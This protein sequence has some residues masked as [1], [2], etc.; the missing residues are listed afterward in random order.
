MVISIRIYRYAFLTF[1]P[2]QKLYYDSS[3][4]GSGAR[5]TPKRERAGSRAW[6]KRQKR[7]WRGLSWKKR[8]RSWKMWKRS[9]RRSPACGKRRGFLRPIRRSRWTKSSLRPPALQTSSASR[10]PSWPWKRPAWAWSK[11]RSSRTTTLPNIFI[12]PI[13]DTKTCGVIEH[14]EAFGV[15]RVAEPIGVVAAVIPTTNPTSTAIFKTLISLKTRNG[16]IISPH[17]RAKGCTIEAAQRCARGGGQ[18]RRARG[19]HLLDR[20]PLA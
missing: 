13:S 6:S 1:A 10:L 18:G 17:P 14:D 7:Q 5:P 4:R 9:R 16:I 15:T 2:Y 20:R 3:C 8:I 12:M 11:T 19:H